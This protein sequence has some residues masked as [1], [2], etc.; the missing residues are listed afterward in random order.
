METKILFQCFQR[1][2]LILGNL[3]SAVDGPRRF[4]S[5]QVI[6]KRWTV[7]R[8]GGGRWQRRL[9][10]RDAAVYRVY[11]REFQPL[12]LYAVVHRVLYN[13]FLRL[14]HEKRF[15]HR[16]HF[17]SILVININHFTPNQKK[18]KIIVLLL[19]YKNTL[20]FIILFIYNI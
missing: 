16:R 7:R 8:G 4:R 19:L 17:C 20:R 6:C 15:L 2:L 10:S 18:R 12:T 5:M 14:S 1:R 11:A 9:R 3:L 13:K